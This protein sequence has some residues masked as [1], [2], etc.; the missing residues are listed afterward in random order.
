MWNH[1]KWILLFSCCCL[2]GDTWPR[3]WHRWANRFCNFCQSSR[4]N[5]LGKSYTA[6]R[7]G[8][9]STMHYH[10]NVPSNR[11]PHPFCWQFWMKP[12]NWLP[13]SFP[14]PN[15]LISIKSDLQEWWWTLL[16][17]GEHSSN[18]L[19]VESL[20]YHLSRELRKKGKNLVE[21]QGL[22]S[23]GKKPS[24]R[25]LK[26][27]EKCRQ[28]FWQRVSWWNFR[29][30]LG[31]KVG[32]QAYKLHPDIICIWYLETNPTRW[33]PLPTINGLRTPISRVLFTPVTHGHSLGPTLSELLDSL[34]AKFPVETA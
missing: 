31:G 34:V 24:W 14:Q 27:F 4:K 3:P 19:G 6:C 21:W 25:S 11:I 22:T 12:V 17:G 10:T 13:R 30:K 9:K 18:F 8:W 1:K 2:S 5:A 23:L 20:H 28:P 29:S 33:G 26:T 16:N 32:W 7:L 15:R